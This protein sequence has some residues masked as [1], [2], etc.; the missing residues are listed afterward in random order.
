MPILS[1]D[2]SLGTANTNYI[3]FCRSKRTKCFPRLFWNGSRKHAFRSTAHLYAP[4]KTKSESFRPNCLLDQQRTYTFCFLALVEKDGHNIN[5]LRTYF[6]IIRELKYV[7]YQT[8]YKFSMY[9][10]MYI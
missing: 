10:Y 7:Y 1:F 5:Q 6:A 8:V 9:M 2:P 3:F 4:M